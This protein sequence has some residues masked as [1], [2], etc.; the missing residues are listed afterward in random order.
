M[1]QNHKRGAIA[2]LIGSLIIVIGDILLGVQIEIFRGIAT[3]NF[4]WMLDVFLVPFIAGLAV[5]LIYKERNGKYLAFLPPVI[6][7]CLSC[8]YLYLTNDQWNENFLHQF[9]IHYWVLAVVL[10]FQASYLGGNWGCVLIGAYKRSDEDGRHKESGQI[11]AN[12]K[13]NTQIGENA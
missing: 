7:R 13:A 1:K 3:F 8:F 2:L 5:A 9:H 12:T 4:L 10:C 6:V 11:R